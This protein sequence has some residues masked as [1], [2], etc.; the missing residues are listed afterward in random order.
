V[1][2]CASSDYISLTIEQLLDIGITG[3][4]KELPMEHMIWQAG[5]G[6][7]LWKSLNLLRLF[8][9]QVIPAVFL[10]MGLKMKNQKPR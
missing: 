6:V 8:F 10:D 2:N 4:C 7:T 1:Y 5:G 3:I 9:Y